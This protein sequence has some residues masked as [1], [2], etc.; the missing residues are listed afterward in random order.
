MHGEGSRRVCPE[1]GQSVIGIDLP[2]HRELRGPRNITTTNIDRAIDDKGR[3]FLFMEHKRPDESMPDGQKRFLFGLARQP[4]TT[5][6]VTSGDTD[7]LELWELGD[8]A[9]RLGVMNWDGLQRRLDDWFA[10][11]PAHTTETF[12]VIVSSLRKLI[13]WPFVADDVPADVNWREIERA[14][15]SLAKEVLV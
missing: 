4:N 14:L 12:A 6:W 1:C 15:R 9:V 5:V 11:P 7:Q 10:Q 3:R 8:T 13:E 2:T